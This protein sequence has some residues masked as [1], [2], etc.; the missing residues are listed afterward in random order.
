MARRTAGLLLGLLVIPVGYLIP[1]LLI[2]DGVERFHDDP[3]S[4]AVAGAAL[5]A[6]WIL[7]DNP[8]GQ[9]LFPAAR[10]S[11]VE[12][13]P[14]SCPAGEPGAAS[15]HAQYTARVRFYTLF[16]IPGPNATVT[17]GGWAESVSL[18]G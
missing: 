2:P 9:L 3:A 12:F 8:L 14:G 4:L 10:V 6:A 16:A 1:R 18:S 15:P 11:A 7:N 17:C 5:E 13:V